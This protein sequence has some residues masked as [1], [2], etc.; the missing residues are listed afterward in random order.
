METE[1]VGDE[2]RDDGYYE[3]VGFLS[4]MCE[5]ICLSHVQCDRLNTFRILPW[6]RG[7]RRLP[8]SGSAVRRVNAG[9]DCV[10]PA[11][12]AMSVFVSLFNAVPWDAA[13]L[14]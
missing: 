1:A 10:S 5:C 3:G 4:W 14:G 8:S 9:A 12:N 13:L 2:D 11:A 7:T 6:K